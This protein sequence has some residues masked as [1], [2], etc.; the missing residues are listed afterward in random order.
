MPAPLIIGHRGAS[1]AAPE[2][3]LIAF[4][5]AIADGADGIEFDVQLAGDGVPVVIH[6]ASLK[7]TGLTPGLINELTSSELEKQDVGTWFNRRFP[8]KADQAYCGV[9]VPTLARVLEHFKSGNALLY[10]ELKCSKRDSPALAG[11]VAKMIHEHQLT[12][13][14][15]VESFGLEAIREI[16]RIDPSVR[17]AALFEPKL[18]RPVRSTRA[19]IQQA[20]EYAA[21]EIALHRSLAN[22][23]TIDDAKRCG[24]DVV[25]WTVDN[26][27][28]IGKAIKNGIQAIITN[29]PALMFVERHEFSVAD[30]PS[31]SEDRHS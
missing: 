11:A 8:A 20:Q 26:R 27:S 4:E 25:V 31:E 23:R 7:R 15:V 28:W 2:N 13:Q 29:Q 1:A 17:T 30:A 12:G 18:T 3:T 21:D 10:I 24:L 16:K 14:V 19:M 22:M 5:K 9:T 6:D